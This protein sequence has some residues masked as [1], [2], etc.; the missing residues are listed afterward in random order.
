MCENKNIKEICF[1]WNRSTDEHSLQ[2][3]LKK[4]GHPEL[5]AVLIP[6]LSDK[7]LIAIV[8]L[9]AETMK[10]HLSEREYHKLFLN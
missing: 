7:E 1:G 4:F 10:A 9:L 5:L 2:A 3:F 8:D 6:R